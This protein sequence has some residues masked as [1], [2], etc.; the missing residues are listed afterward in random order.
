M[1]H[2]DAR[3]NRVRI[4]PGNC[5]DTMRVAAVMT[6]TNMTFRIIPGIFA[7]A[8]LEQRGDLLYILRVCPS[9]QCIYVCSI[10]FEENLS[11]VD[12]PLYRSRVK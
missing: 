7:Y 12:I 5:A 3:C 6:Y 4:F 10:M 1:S 11:C 2:V 8:I 9:S